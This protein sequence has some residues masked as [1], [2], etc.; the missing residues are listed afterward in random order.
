MMVI[1]PLS[2]ARE[3]ISPV[4]VGPSNVGAISPRAVG[5]EGALMIASTFLPETLLFILGSKPLKMSLAS[6][7]R[8]TLVITRRSK[9]REATYDWGLE[10]M[11]SLSYTFKFASTALYSAVR[12]SARILS[13][14]VLASFIS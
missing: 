13:P 4:G 6:E 14:S 8:I 1:F 11:K 9:I 10:F 3:N 7:E 2:D 12:S 5:L